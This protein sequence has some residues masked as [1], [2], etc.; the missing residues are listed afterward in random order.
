M[1]RTGAPSRH[2]TVGTGGVAAR[3]STGRGR[4]FTRPPELGENTR[5]VLGEF[6]GY[7]ADRLEALRA[8]GAI[9]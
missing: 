4:A 7:D 1:R 8:E 5:Q 2:T 6:V 9:A 3:S